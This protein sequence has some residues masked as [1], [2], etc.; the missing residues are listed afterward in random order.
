MLR[1]HPFSPRVPAR[2]AE[3][4]GGPTSYPTVMI[5][6]DS[7]LYPPSSLIQRSTPASPGYVYTC[8]TIMPSANVESPK[9]QWY[10]I[11]VREGSVLEE[12]AS[13]VTICRMYGGSGEIVNTATGP[14]V[15]GMTLAGFPLSPLFSLAARIT[16]K[17]S[18]YSYAGEVPLHLS[19][20]P[21]PS[22]QLP[23]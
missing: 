19:F 11:I 20:A 21:G 23:E 14:A 8:V 5:R 22:P 12:D 10:E 16:M 9:A 18:P 3:E 15:A 17:I 13:N 4:T 1:N 7:A 6:N 2:V